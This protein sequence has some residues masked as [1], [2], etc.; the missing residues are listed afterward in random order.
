MYPP[1]ILGLVACSF[2]LGNASAM[3]ITQMP[4]AESTAAPTTTTTITPDPWQCATENI[5]QYWDVPKPTSSLLDALNSYGAE[6]VAPCRSTAT[7][8]DRLDCSVATW[9]GFT[10]AAPSSVL[11]DYLSYGS[12]A[13][14]FWVSKISTI[15]LLS[16]Y[17]PVTWAKADRTQQ[18]WF[19]LTIAYAECYLADHPID[20]TTTTPLSTISSATTPTASTATGLT[21]TTN[22]VLA[23]AHEIEAWMLVS[24]GIAAAVN[25]IW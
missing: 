12:E 24:T 23:R 1:S 11:T 21:P 22:G 8:L 20:T 3:K 17:C 5:T 14:S 25:A 10:T 4:R 7:G 9:C 16:D 15:S 2:F 19:N 13:A 18:A 6:L